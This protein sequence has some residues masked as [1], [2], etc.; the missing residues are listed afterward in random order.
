MC[1][2][3]VS[4]SLNLP[5]VRR[6]ILRHYVNYCF[7]ALRLS[8]SYKILIVDDRHKFGIETTAVYSNTDSKISVFGRG[9][10][11]VDILR[12]I[13]HELVHAKQHESGDDLS[14]HF[15]H[16]NNEFE[17]EANLVAGEMLNAYTDV[18]GHDE[19]YENP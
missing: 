19:I 4:K 5:A 3:L 14:Q 2:I 18:M 11:F 13:A 9:R 7:R 10:A 16:F 1:R 8:K 15:L 17:D 6:K 12:S